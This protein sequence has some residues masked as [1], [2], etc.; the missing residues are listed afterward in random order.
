MALMFQHLA[1][2]FAKAGYNPTDAD[3][4]QR[5][6]NALAPATAGRMH[7]IDPR[8]GGAMALAECKHELGAGHTDTLGAEY[9]AE[10]AGHAKQ[11]LDHCIHGDYQDCIISKRHYG[12]LFLNPPYGDL[13]TDK[14]ATG[15]QGG[16]GRQRLEKLFCQLTV[17][18]VLFGGV[19]MLIVPGYALDADYSGAG[20]YPA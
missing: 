4:T 2:N 16:K 20:F 15:D 5:L 1:N 14:G 6:L 7:I 8:G 9:D 18:L 3:T 11:V 12:L 19:M 13:V 17:P 10:H